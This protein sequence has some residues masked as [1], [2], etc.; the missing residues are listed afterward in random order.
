VV[1]GASVAGCPA[2]KVLSEF[3]D[4]VTIVERDPL[5]DAADHRRGVPQSAHLHGL[6]YGGRLTLDDI[7]GG[8]GFTA[9]MREVGGPYFD[10]ARHQ[11]FRFPEG[12]IRRAP[13]DLMVVF[14]TRWAMEHQIR[15]LTR[16][17]ANI[18]ILHATVTDLTM[19]SDGNRVTG[20][21]VL[22]DGGEQT[23][24]ADLVVDAAG[25]ASK[26]PKW[27][28]DHGYAPPIESVVRSF[29]GYATVYGHLP[30]DAWPGD[31]KSIA[32]PPFPGT[33]RGGFVVPQENGLV[34][35]MAAGQ[36]RDYPPG[37]V[38]GFG[39]FLK[40]AI[41]PVL[42]DLWQQCEPATEI[43]TTRTS[44]NRLRRW[45]E[46]DRRPERFLAVGDANCAFN[47][48]YGQGITTGAMQSKAL[49]SRLNDLDDLDRL[50][51]GFPAEAMAAC[52]FAWTAATDA[53]MGFEAT[54][55]ENL[56]VADHDPVV[57]EY[58]SRLR[59]ATTLDAGVAG[60]FFRAQ[61]NMQ[62]A[63][64]FDPELVARVERV[65]AEADTAPVDNLRPPAFSDDAVPLGV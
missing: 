25:R 24:E 44:H 10:F 4:R 18:D 13:G 30:E 33:T 1:I 29:L 2:A 51:D 39:E 46:L 62:G 58:F 50:V 48:V 11:A 38:D 52:Q 60:A 20:V 40:S 3:F 49:Q 41:T 59:L 5:P 7:Y 36:S 64:L 19:S 63:L 34:G 43:K 17:V 54:E 55:V 27:L 9:A 26:S 57:T 65:V 15:C 53:D 47:P 37:D 8:G 61:G 16:P 12:W 31:I 42:Y 22:G 56:Q 28:S 14:A 35:I 32:A 6:L 23:I 45:H 21:K